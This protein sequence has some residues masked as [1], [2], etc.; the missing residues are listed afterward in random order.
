MQCY[1]EGHTGHDLPAPLPATPSRPCRCTASRLWRRVAHT[2]ASTFR[3]GRKAQVRARRRAELRLPQTQTHGHPRSLHRRTA[4]A[5]LPGVWASCR[6]RVQRRGLAAA[7][8]SRRDAPATSAAAHR[9]RRARSLQLFGASRCARGA[10]G[11]RAAR[12][13]GRRTLAGSSGLIPRRGCTASRQQLSTCRTG[14]GAARLATADVFLGRQRLASAPPFLATRCCWCC[15][16]LEVSACCLCG[17]VTS[18]Y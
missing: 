17:R 10:H 18:S 3:P 4:D 9:T 5:L 13:W 11:G 14:L 16:V 6:G 15:A 1:S 8:S 12:L 2:A 7:L